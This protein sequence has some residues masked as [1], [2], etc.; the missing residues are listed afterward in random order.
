MAIRWELIRGGFGAH[1]LAEDSEITLSLCERAVRVDFE[2]RAVV[3]GAMA[4]SFA[5]ARTQDRRWEGGRAAL[6]PRAAHVIGAAVVARRPGRALA[7][8]EAVSPPLTLMVLLATTS[9]AVSAAGA[10][11]PWLGAA[12]T[13]SLGAYVSAGWLAAR[14]PAG[15]LVALLSAPRF[16]V[17]KSL[18]LAEL[19][20][21]RGP[22]G[23]Q[24]TERL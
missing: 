17:H 18:V 8:M 20:V 1:G 10:G 14:V 4:S 12:A 24:R 2:P 23:W 21:G 3:R 13:A 5:T 15:D 16:I 22:T 11:S 9:S 19:L 7:A 6:I